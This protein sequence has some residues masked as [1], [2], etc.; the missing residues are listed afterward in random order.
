M[1]ALG[2]AGL[3]QELLEQDPDSPS[4]DAVGVLGLLNADSDAGSP[5]ITPLCTG[6][7]IGPS[8]VVTSRACRDALTRDNEADLTEAAVFGIGPN[9]AEPVDWAHVVDFADVPD[10]RAFEA[11]IQGTSLTVL[12]LAKPLQ[13]VPK[14]KLGNASSLHV[15]SA[16]VQVGYASSAGHGAGQRRV[17]PVYMREVRERTL[18]T[19]AANSGDDSPS[20][21]DM[22]E[23]LLRVDE[24]GELVLYGVASD[25][26]G[27]AAPACDQGPVYTSFVDWKVKSFL[28]EA[29]DWTDPCGSLALRPVCEGEVARSCSRPGQG[30]RHI[31][32]QDCTEH[33][34]VCL[35]AEGGVSC[36]PQHL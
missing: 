35:E 31:I 10:T 32:D 34:L 20:C 30:E 19:T 11:Q 2:D 5:T 17:A 36:A 15:G 3:S 28:E 24:A 26:S 25:V 9:P 16:F 23:A 12:H 21:R 14:A 7:L 22:G 27:P 13:A 33:G 6:T 29:R 18:E 4:L 1:L 8:T